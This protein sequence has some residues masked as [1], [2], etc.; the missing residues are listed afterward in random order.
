MHAANASRPSRGRGVPSNLC[1]PALP[2]DQR[3]WGARHEKSPPAK[4]AIFAS[5]ALPTPVAMV[6]FACFG[7][8]A[9]D[10]FQKK[11]MI[12]AGPAGRPS[13]VQAPSP[14]LPVSCH[15]FAD[16]LM[17]IRGEIASSGP[18]K[19]VRMPLATRFSYMVSD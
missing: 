15:R 8:C 16:I 12:A 3:G 7:L 11:L 9:A 17:A 10:S 13:N 2:T 1:P 6:W 18:M 4:N 14:P 5:T 19:N